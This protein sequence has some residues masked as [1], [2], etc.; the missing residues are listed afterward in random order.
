MYINPFLAGVLSTIGAEITL[1]FVAALVAGLPAGRACLTQCHLVGLHVDGA[2][3]EE[4]VVELLA[5]QGHIYVGLLLGGFCGVLLFWGWLPEE[6]VFQLFDDDFVTRL[7]FFSFA[8]SHLNS[9]LSFANY[10]FNFQGAFPLTLF[11]FRN[12][13]T[14]SL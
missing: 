5:V 1:L 10:M 13:E 9:Y 12:S 3:A 2:G 7:N 6:Q 4:V 8:F 14:F 11:S